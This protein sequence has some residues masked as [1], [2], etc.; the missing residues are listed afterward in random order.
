M[1]LHRL[2]LGYSFCVFCLAGFYA[3]GRL[4]LAPGLSPASDYLL[5]LGSVGFSL[6]LGAWAARWR[7]PGRGAV[8]LGCLLCAL[9]A[10]L[11]FWI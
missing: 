3:A 6:P 10:E 11:L 5:L 1:P 2:F 4:L 7:I 8:L 9:C